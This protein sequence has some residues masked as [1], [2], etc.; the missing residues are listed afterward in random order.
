MRVVA[1]KLPQPSTNASLLRP[2]SIQKVWLYG[3]DPGII[4]ALANTGIRIMI[5][6]ANGDIPRLWQT[7]LISPGTGTP[8][9][10]STGVSLGGKVKVSTVHSMAVLHISEQPSSA[11]FN[12]GF[13]DLMKGLLRFNDRT[14]S[15]FMINSYPYFASMND[16]RQKPW[17]SA[18]SRRS[19]EIPSEYQD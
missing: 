12:P 13:V 4:R 1:D 14:R 17:R 2:M 3:A 15:P 16:P 5:G 6:D 11:R 18:C 9:A 10:P 8:R 19:R 7:N